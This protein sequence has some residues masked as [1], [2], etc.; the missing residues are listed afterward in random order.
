MSTSLLYHAWKIRDCKYLK[1][2]YKGGG[3]QIHMEYKPAALKCPD[4]GSTHSIKKGTKLRSFLALPIGSKPVV[5]LLHQQRILCL[6]CNAL[7]WVQPAFANGTDRHIK[8]FVRYVLDL[9]RSMNI[10]DVAKHLGVSWTFVKDIQ[11]DYLQ[12]NFGKP[13]LKNVRYLGIDEVQIGKGHR[14][15]TIVL[16][17]ESGAVLFV[18]DGKG[19]DALLPFWKRLK[20]SSAKVEAVSIDM[21]PAYISSVMEHLPGAAIVFDHFHVVKLMNEKLSKLRRALYRELTDELDKKVLKGIRWLLLKNPENLDASK[22]EPERLAEALKLN[23]P[24]AMAYY[25][26]EDLRQIWSQADKETAARVLDDWADRAQASGVRILQEMG[27]SLRAHR[28]G[29]LSWYDH[30]LSN[31]ALEGLNNKIGLVQR[32]SYGIR[33][34]GFLKLKIYACKEVR[35]SIVG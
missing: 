17:L 8:A 3:V 32:Q 12:K 35:Y 4:C 27:K 23:E 33:D 25:M 21:S 14:Y 5:L 18:G 26:K 1:T 2:E 13:R 6:K 10:Q 9:L 31:G 29:I 24:L 34:K 19:G 7:R 16:D 15:F 30:P 22:R 20:R 11:K 28:Y